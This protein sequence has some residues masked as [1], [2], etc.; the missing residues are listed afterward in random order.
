[1]RQSTSYYHSEVY[2][3]FK[4][5]ADNEYRSIVQFFE[6]FEKEIK[7]LEFDEYFELLL[8]Y[9]DALFETAA[10]EN[11]LK[12][13]DAAIGFTI[14]NNIKFYQGKDVFFE[15]LYKKAASQYNLLEYDKAEHIIRE[16]IKMEPNNELTVRFLK[17]CIGQTKPSYIQTGR[18]LSV[19]I[20]LITA[21]L[22]SIELTFIRPFYPVHEE[23]VE[24]GRN[25]LFILGWIVLVS[26]DLFRK[27]Q[28]NSQVRTFVSKTKKHKKRSTSGKEKMMA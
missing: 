9:A 18:A 1:M 19:F 20:F 7:Q 17:K 2:Q 28:V 10:Y 24:T 21:L 14:E 23:L 27:Y 3:E 22:I 13:V 16:L 15:L 6:E 25:A 5:I 12:V 8:A 11:H 4:E 26:G